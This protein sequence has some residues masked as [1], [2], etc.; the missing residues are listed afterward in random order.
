MVPV[1]HVGKMAVG[2]IWGITMQRLHHTPPVR[3]GAN[4]QDFVYSL[5]LYRAFSILKWM[6]ILW[7]LNAPIS[8][9]PGSIL[10]RRL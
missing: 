4:C 6:W 10:N 2:L 5:F 8:N 9:P 3:A 7:K 1:L